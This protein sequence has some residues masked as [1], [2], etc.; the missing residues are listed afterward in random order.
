MHPPFRL[1]RIPERFQGIALMI[2]SML[3]FAIMGNSV[4]YVSQFLPTEQVVLLRNLVA[5][6]LLSCWVF[7]KRRQ[8]LRTRRFASHLGRAALG[9]VSMHT[10]F[11][12]LGHMPLA[13]ATALSFTTPIFT[14]ILAILIF[15]ERSTKLRWT[16]VGIG[17]V[18]AIV[19]V[20]PSAQGIDP[21]AVY[22]LSSSVLIAIISIWVKSLSRTETTASMLFYM[23]LLMT[24]FGL[25]FGVLHWQPMNLHLW[26]GALVLAT[27]SLLAHSL[28]IEAYKHTEMTVLMPFDFT[29][30]IFTAL[31]A[32]LWFGEAIDGVTLLGAGIIVIGSL[33]GA[34]E[35][36]RRVTHLMNA[37]SQPSAN[38]AAAPPEIIAQREE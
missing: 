26:L 22:A 28:L 17:L 23:A 7:P 5:L 38:L 1:P 29:R 36:A 20:R 27:A 3:C 16:A 37:T 19:I 4:R 14:T 24:L 2:L 21:V 12:A 18:G 30:L 31:L 9:I 6:A 33:I 15:R 35:G 13:Q 34:R 8:D 25:P 11:Y 10:W 32:Y